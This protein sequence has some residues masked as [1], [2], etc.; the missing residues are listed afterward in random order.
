MDRLLARLERHIGRYAVPNLILYVV[1][2]M[3]VVWVLSRSHPEGIGRLVLDM[4]A[5]RRGEVWRLATFL[6]I[7]PSS[8]S[9]WVLVN[10]YFTWWVGSSLEK[11]WGAFKFNAFY[12]IGAL[13]TVVA[14]MLAGPTT[15]TW[16]DSSLFLAFATTFPDVTI[17]LFFVLPVRVKWLGIFAALAI[18]AAFALGDWA[19]R[20]PIMA[21]L[22]NYVLFF[23]EHWRRVWRNRS[24]GVRQKARREEMRSNA[25]VFGQRVCAICGAREADG[26]D[27]R[28]CSCEKCGGQQRP[29]CLE[30]ARNH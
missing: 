19:T 6:F 20:A 30:H 3:A 27:I 8:S 16:L 17:L 26:T 10:L 15:N 24:V 23:G 25:P 14:A 7:P 22:V 18:G 11:H 13:A 9:L 4:D 12:F 5:V 21:A 2:G 29:L 1:G 28:V